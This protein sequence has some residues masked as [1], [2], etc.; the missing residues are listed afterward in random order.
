L[1]AVSGDQEVAHPAKQTVSLLE[2]E[3][4]FVYD[5]DVRLSGLT[6][7]DALLDPRHHA[8]RENVVVKVDVDLRNY[9]DVDV[10]CPVV[11][12]G[13]DYRALYVLYT[14][15]P[16]DDGAFIADALELL[17]EIQAPFV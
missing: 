8:I 3:L 11:V 17:R 14:H 15:D 13:L 4:V 9:T 2:T 7:N 16:L 10:Y 12:V 6:A 1:F 5:Y